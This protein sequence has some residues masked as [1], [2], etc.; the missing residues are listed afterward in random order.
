[1]G[2]TFTTDKYEIIATGVNGAPRG[3]PHCI[4]VGCLMIDG[5]CRRSVHA[6]IN[7][8][9]QATRQGHSLMGAYAFITA[10]P[11]ILCSLAMIQ[12]G[13]VRI[14]Y[15]KV[16]NTDGAFDE[17]MLAFDKAG[18]ECIKYVHQ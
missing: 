7:G 16:Y 1:M 13:I 14:V 5:H 10:R 8:I 3:L 17:V 9:I 15:D 6:E 12:A 18:I 11:C 4:D 2:V